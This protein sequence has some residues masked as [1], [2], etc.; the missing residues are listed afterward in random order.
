MVI[1]VVEGVCSIKGRVNIYVDRGLVHDVNMR[2]DDG[3]GDSRGDT[4]W[5]RNMMSKMVLIE[6]GSRIVR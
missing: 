4:W 3:H 6:D 1:V 2:S 5:R